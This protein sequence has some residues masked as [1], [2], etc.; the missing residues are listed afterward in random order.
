MGSSKRLL[1]A[2]LGL[3]WTTATVGAQVLGA[4]ATPTTTPASF[5]VDFSNN[6]IWAAGSAQT[7][8]L[9]LRTP[10][11]HVLF[12]D[13]FVLAPSD[14]TSLAPQFTVCDGLV[15]SDSTVLN[16]PCASGVCTTVTCPVTVP[17]TYPTTSGMVATASW[18]D[19]LQVPLLGTAAPFCTTHKIT[20]RSLLAIAATA[21][22]VTTSALSATTTAPISSASPV[23]HSTPAS[24][25][26]PA[27]S[28]STSSDPSTATANANTT[29]STLS[30]PSSSGIAGRTAGI[31]GGF[32]GLLALLVIGGAVYWQYRRR[33]S[34]DRW[35]PDFGTMNRSSRV[36]NNNKSGG[37]LDRG[38][39]GGKTGDGVV[40]DGLFV[41]GSDVGIRKSQQMRQSTWNGNGNGQ[42]DPTTG[43]SRT[44][45]V[46]QQQQQQQRY[47]S[48]DYSYASPSIGVGPQAPVRMASRPDGGAPYNINAI[49]ESGGL[50]RVSTTR[51]MGLHVV[52]WD[53]GNAAAAAAAAPPLPT[54]PSRYP[55][56]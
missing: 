52:N 42:L 43:T 56:G 18:K 50:D 9:I 34:S 35:D 12:V 1:A 55:S 31:I 19:C 10:I 21:G 2:G 33:R 30:T 11:E 49:Q 5:E 28:S 16:Q 27:P 48:M 14:A 40:G 26:T 41:G 39:D 44:S 47:P 36:Y 38:A 46:R 7:V 22:V 17:A 32:I 8:T 20:Q 54:V 25:S 13:S 51:T 24:K 6:N 15:I 37:F 29:T 3:I 23:P 45:T 4:P 53:Q